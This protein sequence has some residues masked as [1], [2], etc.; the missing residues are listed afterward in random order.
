MALNKLLG[1]L[2]TPSPML[3]IIPSPSAPALLNTFP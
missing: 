3:S 1:M 2:F